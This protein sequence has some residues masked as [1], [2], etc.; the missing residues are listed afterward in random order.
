M[1]R[2]VRPFSNRA[3]PDELG[4][5]IPEGFDSPTTAQVLERT[6]DGGLAYGCRLVGDADIE[7]EP[8]ALGL[9][10]T[11]VSQA[12]PYRDPELLLPEDP[13]RGALS[14]QAQGTAVLQGSGVSWRVARTPHDVLRDDSSL[15]FGIGGAA[16]TPQ[17][18][19]SRF[20]WRQAMWVVQRSGADNGLLTV[21]V[22]QW[23]R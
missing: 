17:P 5:V 8:F 9:V 15:I 6:G 1:P 10:R 22:E 13:R 14:I 2:T 23:A 16:A 7:M 20:S 3:R 12:A 19:L 21:T 18:P 11:M 4:N